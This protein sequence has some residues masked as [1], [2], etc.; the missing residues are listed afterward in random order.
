MMPGPWLD[1]VREKKK[2][3]ILL[4]FILLIGLGF[5]F[6]PGEKKEELFQPVGA[7][8]PTPAG[9][10]TA[11]NPQPAEKIIVDVKGAVKKPG[12]YTLSPSSRLYQAIEMAGGFSDQADQNL[13][14]GA[15]L[16]QDGEAIY[17][18]VKGEIPGTGVG[19]TGSGGTQTGGEKGK[20]NINQANGE[21]LQTLPG[22]GP[23][24]ADAIIKYRQ[25]NGVFKN[26]EE[27][28][29]VSGIGDKT[30]EKIKPQIT[31]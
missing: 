10:K 2:W 6:Y 26:I 16:L 24:K 8:T 15:K 7:S 20:V 23:S 19:I 1:W 29:N 27:I 25:E 4:T 5:L 21:E 14:N 31:V 11:G 17:I 12:I 22:I 9:V 13:V 18:P 3:L 30:F 28:K